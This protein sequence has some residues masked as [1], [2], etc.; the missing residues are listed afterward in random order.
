MKKKFSNK[1]KSSKQARKQR[2]Y[3]ANAPLHLKKKF[4]SV[5]LS[6][7]LR[8]KFGM[9]SLS[10]RKGDEIKIMVGKFKGKTG[11]IG[12]IDIK[13]QRVAIDGIQNKKK[14]GTKVNVYFNPSNLLLISADESDKKRFK[15]IK[16]TGKK[17]NAP[18]KTN[19]K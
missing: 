4:L 1:W 6:K 8:K 10:L 5:H 12:I 13:N 16:K 3:R 7:D 15:L 19:S 9:R 17:K 18:E 11:K 14:D 2:K